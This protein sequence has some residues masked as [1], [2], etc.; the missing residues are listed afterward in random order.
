MA[1]LLRADVPELLRTLAE[2]ERVAVLLEDEIA[3]CRVE[4]L[5]R[6]AEDCTADD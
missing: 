2:L 5:E 4:T 3:L 6:V 1:E